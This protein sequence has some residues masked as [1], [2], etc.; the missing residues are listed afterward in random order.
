[1]RKTW[2][3]L[4]ALA[5]VFSL[6]AC[7]SGKAP[8]T[9]VPD[10]A[11]TDE[12]SSQEAPA[13]GPQGAGPEFG[14]ASP[15]AGGLTDPNP[16]ADGNGPF[17]NAVLPDL[18]AYAEAAMTLNIESVSE[19]IYRITLTDPYIA[20]AYSVEDS[21]FIYQWEV[22]AEDDDPMHTTVVFLAAVLPPVSEGSADQPTTVKMADVELARGNGQAV[23]ECTNFGYD[24]DAHTLTWEIKLAEGGR[25]RLASWKARSLMNYGPDTNAIETKDASPS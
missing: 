20:G 11:S 1:M 2:L 16:S 25:E 7:N 6:A 5:L 9:S 14:S 4:L 15:S 22:L 8:D 3:G 21:I 10:G 12:D 18:A 17:H 19:D 13:E 24:L 23:A